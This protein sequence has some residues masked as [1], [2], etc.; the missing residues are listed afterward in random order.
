MTPR[1]LRPAPPA[2]QGTGECAPSRG[3]P[4]YAG[5]FGESTRSLWEAQ[6]A[7][8]LWAREPPHAVSRRIYVLS[9][10]MRFVLGDKDWVLGPAR[11][12]RS[13]PTCRTGSAALARN[14]RRS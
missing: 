4:C 3:D 6:A 9:G 14:T 11:S 2:A 1:S 5:I 10:H 7:W 13:T 12:P 8:L